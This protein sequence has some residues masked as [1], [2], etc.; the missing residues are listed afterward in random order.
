MRSY[1]WIQARCQMTVA[2]AEKRLSCQLRPTP[3][4]TI[5]VASVDVS[6]PEARSFGCSS[7]RR[8]AATVAIRLVCA[9]GFAGYTLTYTIAN[10]GKVRRLGPQQDTVIYLRESPANEAPSMR[11]RTQHTLLELPRYRGDQRDEATGGIEAPVDP[12]SPSL[13]SSAADGGLVTN[14]VRAAFGRAA[15][16]I[17]GS[18]S[19]R[20]YVFRRSTS[21]GGAGGGWVRAISWGRSV[22]AEA[23]S[24]RDCCPW[25]VIGLRCS[26]GSC[27]WR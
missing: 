19:R 11:G 15:S 27:R 6:I 24:M 2:A 16:L 4:A 26:P 3:P 7:I 12:Q 21:R 1:A 8:A 5:T 14:S 17:V 20:L 25:R 18:P 10:N 23:V 13:R 22:V 9:E